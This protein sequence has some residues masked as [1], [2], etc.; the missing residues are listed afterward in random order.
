M[1]NFMNIDEIEFEE[2]CKQILEKKLGKTFRIFG[3]GADGGIDIQANDNENI[4]GQAKFYRNTSQTDTV[5][6]IK[7]EANRI[8]PKK[9]EQYY[10][11]IGR[12]MS[13]QN[14]QK[15]YENFQDILKTKENIFTMKEINELLNKDE[16]SDI[17]RQH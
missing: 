11:F 1:F 3:R 17:V 14:I 8:N 7:K 16:Y 6:K 9:I 15:I 12:E 5:G 13:P 10:L 4:I 2:L